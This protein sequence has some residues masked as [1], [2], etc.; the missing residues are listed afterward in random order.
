MAF[1][2]GGANS[3]ADTAFDVANSC[4]FG[5]DT[6]LDKDNANSSP[7]HA[8]KYTISFWCKKCN[9]SGGGS[10]AP[11][12]NGYTLFMSS[13]SGTAGDAS[14][15]YCQI[16][17]KNEDDIRW[18]E[19][20][21]GTSGQ[22]E[23][24]QVF[25]D[26]AAW[27]HLVFRFDSTDGT[28]DDRMRIYVNGAQVTSFQTRTN[29]DQNTDSW[30]G[31]ASA[32]HVIG[33]TSAR[34]FDGYLAEFVLIDGQSLAP[35]SFGEYDSDSPNIWKPIDVSGLTFGTHGYY[36]DF[37]DSSALGNDA[38]GGTDFSVTNLAAYDQCQDSP[39]NNWAVLNNLDHYYTATSSTGATSTE[40]ATKFI[41]ASGNRGFA[42][43]TFGV[44]AGKW[45]WE[46]KLHAVSKGFLG[47]CNNE[48]LV[49]DS[50]PQVNA[51]YIYEATPD[52]RSGAQILTTGVASI[53]T[54]DIMNFALDMD[55][56]AFY[57]G[58][59]NTYMNS[60]DPE[61]GASR[62]GA[63]SELFTTGRAIIS[64]SGE[65]F[66]NLLNTS[67]TGGINTSMNFGCPAYANSSDAADANGY[68]A[69]EFAPPSGYLALCTK[70]LGSDGG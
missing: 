21:D 13:G 18:Q 32:A 65:M 42:R 3:A 26:P 43:S 63:I 24:N 62:T 12:E 39:T 29:I 35:T 61:S 57:I 27:H 5:T 2:I 52:F 55:N 1:L 58:V 66:A 8:D 20:D 68:G 7:T 6:L 19:Y 33:G 41:I 28:A 69:F 10:G 37:E 56:N 49:D 14:D 67:T 31:Y 38:N 15:H 47:I 54:N 53:S 4:R 60:G 23:T 36:L 51:V 22:L 59:N 9:T 45:Y 16:Y 30:V 34:F 50:T 11:A 44:T 40:G 46:C 64:D 25:R 48:I 17:F 70:N